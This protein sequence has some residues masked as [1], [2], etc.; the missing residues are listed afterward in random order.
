[1]VARVVTAKKTLAGRRFLRSV[2]LD[3]DFWDPNALT[4]YSITPHVFLVLRRVLAALRAPQGDDRAWTV[5]GPFGSGKSAFAV[6]LARLLSSHGQVDAQ[7]KSLLRGAGL[8]DEVEE[9]LTPLKGSGLLPVLVSGRRAGLSVCLLEGALRAMERFQLGPMGAKLRKAVRHDLKRTTWDSNHL[10]NRLEA[11]QEVATSQRRYRGLIIVIDELGKLL[12]F[13]AVHLPGEVFILQELAEWACRSGGQPV[14]LLGILHQA[15]EHY[16]QL[17]DGTTRRE[18]AKVQGRFGDIVFLEPPEQQIHFAASAVESLGLE[19][20]AKTRRKLEAVAHHL[21]AKGMVP[22]RFAERG[23]VPLASKSYPLHPLVL[24]ALPLLFRGFAQNERSL[25]AYL[26]SLEPFG[27]QWLVQN[28]SQRMI[29]LPDLYDYFVANLSNSLLRHATARRW[30]EAADTLDRL[31]TA[32]ALQMSALKSIALLSSLGSGSYLRPD[33]ALIS[34][35]LCDAP[36]KTSISLALRGLKQQS[37]VVFRRFSQSYRI[38]EGSDVDLE[39]RIAAGRASVARGPVTV[40][41]L[42]RYL[43]QRPLLARRHSHTHGT[44]RFFGVTLA[45][46]IPGNVDSFPRNPRGG[47]VVCAVPGSK[48]EAKRIAEWACSGALKKR[49]DLLIALPSDSSGIRETATELLSLQWAWDN[50]PELRDDRVA[51]RELGEAIALAERLLS[52]ALHRLLDPRPGPVG[53]Q[54]LWFWAGRRYPVKSRRDVTEVLSVILDRVFSQSPRIQNE[55]VNRYVLSSAAAAARRNL[56]ERMLTGSTQPA[57]G[58]VGF[59]PER[60]MYESVLRASGLHRQEGEKWFFSAPMKDDPTSLLPVWRFLEEQVFGKSLEPVSVA[61]LFDRLHAPPFGVTPGVAPVLLA[62]FLLAHRGETSLYREATFVPEISIADFEL[63]LHR[64]EMFQV[65]GARFQGARAF[66]LRRMAESFGV[67][68][69]IAAVARA[70]VRRV[71]SFPRSSWQTHR[72]SSPVLRLRQAFEEARSPEKLIFS[73]L[74]LA[75]GCQ[76][77]KEDDTLGEDDLE[78]FFDKLNEALETWAAFES[79]LLGEARDLLAAVCG[80]GPGEEGWRGLRSLGRRLVGKPLDPLLVPLV[81]RLSSTEDDAD[82][83]RSVVALVAERPPDSWSDADME[84]FRLRATELGRLLGHA[85]HLVNAL[86]SSEEAEAEAL[87]A[88]LKANLRRGIPAHVARAAL[89]RLLQEIE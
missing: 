36:A 72:L 21:V 69:G 35:A 61:K 74:P 18:W 80:F 59:P 27:L 88:V 50:T 42:E 52:E 51:R 5:T 86:T 49:M 9:L 87:L 55:L 38:W 60:S 68:A 79:R 3:Q 26:T 34:L 17:L 4:G 39:A 24:A 1:M 20:D 37:A 41:T 11:L 28:E 48:I 66:V 7:L 16:S 84:R 64:P 12:E 63:L 73:E 78:R 65:A 15:F 19:A 54:C 44:L 47:T 29:R 57:L 45:D 62:A 77:F 30:L 40:A 56:V 46:G 85:R 2:R 22:P 71:R 53:S 10:K 83:L 75:I 58:I 32:D 70:L 23:F 33:D 67:P 8:E 82:A 13:A 6:F 14:L 25:F 43:A 31:R 89:A 81:N 76:P